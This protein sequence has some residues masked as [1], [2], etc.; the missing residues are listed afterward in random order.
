[1]ALE[2]GID[3]RVLFYRITGAQSIVRIEPLLK[4]LLCCDWRLVNDSVTSVHFVWETSCKIIERVQH[5]ESAILN[6]LNNSCIIEDKSNLAYLQ[7]IMSRNSLLEVLETYVAIGLAGATKWASN[8]WESMNS[9]ECCYNRFL[10]T[11]DSSLLSSVLEVSSES[12]ASVFIPMVSNS[13]DWWIVKA[14]KSNCGQDIWILHSYNYK[15]VLPQ[16]SLHEGDFHALNVFKMATMLLIITRMLFYPISFQYFEL[17]ILCMQ[18][19]P[20]SGSMSL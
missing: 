20:E 2:T 8:R 16:L 5:L 19:C 17:S 13:D 7:L 3:S 15:D 9:N 18:L 4:P 6:K 12:T 14:S 1:M 11:G 10:T